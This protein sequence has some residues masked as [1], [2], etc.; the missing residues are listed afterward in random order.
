MASLVTFLNIDKDWIPHSRGQFEIIFGALYELYL[1]RSKTPRVCADLL[2]K[3]QHYLHSCWSDGY[4]DPDGVALDYVAFS[5]Y[6][7][8]EKMEVLKAA[9]KLLEDFRHDRLDPH[10]RWNWERKGNFISAL[11][12]FIGLMREDIAAS[13]Q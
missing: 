6:P 2:P 4:E 12:E 10:L 7:R 13:S 9:E 3:I 1:D 11:R 8:K 5:R